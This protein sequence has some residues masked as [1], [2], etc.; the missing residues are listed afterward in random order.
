MCDSKTLGLAEKKEERKERERGEGKEES[1]GGRREEGRGGRRREG[2]KVE[3]KKH[4]FSLE[5]CSGFRSFLF[6]KP[7]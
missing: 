7:S 4:W 3:R 6:Q 1:K 2:K 5:G